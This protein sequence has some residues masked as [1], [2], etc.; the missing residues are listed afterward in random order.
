[1]TGV[2]DSGVPA[3]GTPDVAHGGDHG[4]HDSLMDA[5]DWD[6]RYRDEGALWG[7]QVTFAARTVLAA[8]DAEH[9]NGRTAVD[10]ACGSGRHALWLA[11]HGW[12][13]VAVDFSRE[14]VDQGRQRS[15][16]EGTVVDWQLGDVLG[17]EPSEPVDLVL[18]AFLHLE[19][20]ALRTV[21]A[22]GLNALTPTGSLLYI[23]HARDNIEHGT[24]GPQRPE[25]LP[26]PADLAAIADGVEVRELAHIRRPVPDHRDAID[27]VL[28]ASPWTAQS[29]G[30]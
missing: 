29:S 27:I 15:R 14:A 28:W 9:G 8:L 5:S 7:E 26:T 20:G 30:P 19:A 23:G 4:E 11:R 10:L 16:D 21:L 17:W 25:V 24:G 6:R 22:R 12:Q 3:G 2:P 13:V 18:I 1:M